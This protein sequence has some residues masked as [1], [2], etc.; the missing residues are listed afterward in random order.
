MKRGVAAC[1]AFMEG[2]HK[3]QRTDLENT[4]KENSV[5]S[6]RNAALKAEN[7]SLKQYILEKKFQD[8]DAQIHRLQAEN[9]ELKGKA[10]LLCER[11]AEL[12]AV[13]KEKDEFQKEIKTLN[14]RVN[15]ADKKLNEKVRELSDELG[16]YKTASE[17]EIQ[18]NE[19]LKE[20]IQELEDS[21]KKSSAQ[22]LSLEGVVL[23]HFTTKA[24]KSPAKKQQPPQ[25]P[26]PPPPHKT[27][28][29]K[30]KTKQ[31]SPSKESKKSSGNTSSKESSMF[32]ALDFF[33]DNALI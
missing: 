7:E 3:R 4:K 10:T 30:P 1:L 25:P 12:N 19:L 20:R 11:E 23:P 16:K 15:A 8:Q 21:L 32:S 24:T 17:S 5:L 18:L 27:P 6:K 26:L 13:R 2:C 29:Q 22:N 14:E 33:T 31:R 28:T 9:R